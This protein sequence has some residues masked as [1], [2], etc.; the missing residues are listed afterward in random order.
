MK[1]KML[2]NGLISQKYTQIKE[3]ENFVFNAP[4]TFIVEDTK[5]GRELCNIHFQEGAIKESGVNGIFNEDVIAMVIR[6]LECF[7][8]SEFKCKENEKAIEKLQE[9]LMWLRKRTTDRE[10][11]NVEGTHI[12]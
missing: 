2:K 11:R 4:T 7:Q 5:E 10:I 12:V 6:R 9:S 3:N 8:A 1:F